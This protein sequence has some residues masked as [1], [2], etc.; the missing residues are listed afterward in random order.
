MLTLGWKK[1]SEKQYIRSHLSISQPREGGPCLTLRLPGATLAQG[2]LDQTVGDKASPASG[3]GC[4]GPQRVQEPMQSPWRQAICLWGRGE[5]RGAQDHSRVQSRTVTQGWW[6]Q[7]ICPMGGRPSA[8]WGGGE[9]G[10]PS[11]GEATEAKP[12]RGRD[13]GVK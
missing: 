13:R 1:L 5:G 7:A 2:C 12:G 4:A 3:W 10:E 8:L 9:G 6:R 11:L